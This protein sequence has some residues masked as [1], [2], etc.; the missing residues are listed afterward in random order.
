MEVKQ[1]P[2]SAEDLRE[3]IAQ[4]FG[5][6]NLR[7]NMRAAEVKQVAEKFNVDTMKSVETNLTPSWVW[8]PKGMFHVAYERGLLDLETYCV[9]D[10]TE[11]GLPDHEDE[12][13]L[14]VLL[15][16]CSDFMNE[17]ILLTKMVRKMGAK[18]ARSPKYHCKLAGKGIKYTWGN[19]KMCYR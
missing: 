2:R 3:E 11:K 17:E 7:A 15:S 1:K 12:T 4:R 16:K 13:S 6:K 18:L 14:V 5:R 9:E 19:A 8:K 10:F